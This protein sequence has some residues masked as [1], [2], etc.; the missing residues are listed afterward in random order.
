M[1]SVWLR[2]DSVAIVR[3]IQKSIHTILTS[4]ESEWEATALLQTVEELPVLAC[5]FYAALFA[6]TRDILSRFRSTNPTWLTRP[7]SPHH[8]AAPGW[9]HIV[10]T[11]EKRVVYLSER[12]R[13]SGYDDACGQLM[14]GIASKQPFGSAHFD[15]ALTSPPYA[16]RIDYIKGALPELAILHADSSAVDVLRANTT[17]SPVVRRKAP[18]ELVIDS[19]CGNAL[20]DRI[21]AHD[22]KA[23]GTYYL[24]WM[25][26]YLHDLQIGLIETNRSVRRGGPICVVVQDSHYK[27]VRVDLQQIVTETFMAH[28]RKL[29]KRFDFPVRMS[30]ARMNP[31]ARRYL[32]QRTNSESVLVFA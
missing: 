29:V 32:Q 26:R 6:A 23:S 21:A 18:I 20:L 25:T 16:T 12:L 28:G 27:E 7:V 17:G 14:T 11:F 3:A 22:S 24:P 5:F 1:L 15:G 19:Q 13:N 4:I 10:S 30:R 31:R 2:S 9:S 8:R